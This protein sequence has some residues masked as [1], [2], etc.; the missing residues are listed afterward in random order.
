MER[1]EKWKEGGRKEGWEGIEK[2]TG[3]TT[4]RMGEGREKGGRREG[5]RRER[6][7]GK[8]RLC[9]RASKPEMDT[10]RKELL[11]MFQIFMYT[12]TRL[13]KVSIVPTRPKWNHGS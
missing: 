2:A 11:F 5:G 10:E 12:L 1:A 6:K 13:Q 9:R 7:K 8:L 4:G 3:K